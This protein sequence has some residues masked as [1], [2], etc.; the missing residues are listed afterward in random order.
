MHDTRGNN[1]ISMNFLRLSR[2]R[3][4]TIYTGPLLFNILPAH[5]RELD[6]KHFVSSIKQYFILKA[7]YS[8]DEI[9]KDKFVDI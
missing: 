1:N 5:I 9:L 4:G 7:F 3:I 8:I 2:S 6:I